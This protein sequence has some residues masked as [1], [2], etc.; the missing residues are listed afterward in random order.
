MRERFQNYETLVRS[1]GFFHELDHKKVVV[2]QGG[3]VT[4]HRVK[5]FPLIELDIKKL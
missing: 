2:V 5:Y 1:S 4:A 3:F